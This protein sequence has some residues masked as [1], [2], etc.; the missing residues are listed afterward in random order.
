MTSTDPLRSQLVKLL[1]WEDAHVGFDKAVE[2]L[3]P[4]LRGARPE[5]FEHSVWQI[6]EHIR[7]AQADILSF[8]GDSAYHEHKWPDD[9]WPSSAAPADEAAWAHSLSAFHRDLEAMKRLAHDPKVDLFAT[10]PHGSG[11]QTYL[12]ELLVVADHTSYHVGQ[13]VDVRRALGAWS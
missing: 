1:D 9:Y 5:G 3:A 10:V 7:L 13:I 8:C 6:V 2:G 12:R 11:P 4:K